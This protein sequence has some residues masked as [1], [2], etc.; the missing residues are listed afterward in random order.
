MAEGEGNDAGTGAGWTDAI[1]DEGLKEALSKF[2]SEQQLL[3]TLGLEIHEG[4]NGA[5]DWRE[6]L[7]GELK[8]VAERFASTEDAVRAIVAYQKRDGQVRVPGKEATEDEIKAYTKAVGVPENVDGYEF[9]NLPK[10]EVTDEITASRKAWAERFHKLQVPAET[11]KV[12]TLALQED[13][14]AVNEA[15]LKADTEFAKSQEDDLRVEWKGEDYERNVMLATRAL[16]EL[17]ER[18]GV[19]ITDL[20]SI[21]TKD[22]RF[23]LDRADILK[24]F[25]V[26]GREMAEGLLGSTLT[27]SEKETIGEEI[28]AVREQYAK[29]QSERNTKLANSLYQKEL[30]LIAKQ[31]GAK[32]IVGKE[33]RSA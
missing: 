25:A 19:K 27:D 8:E 14:T 4:G 17:S 33:G 18:S 32:P 2:E 21:E 6:E 29:A 3:D 1:E 30:V 15:A 22:G 16:T 31:E 13:V 28:I 26:V 11:A 9:P 5:L 10:D 7:P 20:K 24:V 23:L 12:L